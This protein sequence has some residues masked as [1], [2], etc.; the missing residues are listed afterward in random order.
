MDSRMLKRWLQMPAHVGDLERL[1]ARAALPRDLASMRHVFQQ[2]L[3]IKS[4]LVDLL[5]T[6]FNK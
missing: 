4:L 3:V 2:L 6:Y 5:G 1:L